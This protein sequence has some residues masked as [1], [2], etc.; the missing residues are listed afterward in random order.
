MLEE[1]PGAS[2]AEL[3]RRSFVTAQTMNGVVGGLAR[4]GLVER[5]DHPEHGRILA[6]VLTEEG[7]SL[8]A[9]AHGRVRVIE[10]RMLGDLRQ[11][12]GGV[13][14][15]LLRRCTLALEREEPVPVTE[16]DD[17]ATTV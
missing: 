1:A 6:T 13:L 8:L 7:R 3:A 14:L 10:D 17:G 5:H 15:D 9:R 2:S 4:S 16:R 12:E 11:G